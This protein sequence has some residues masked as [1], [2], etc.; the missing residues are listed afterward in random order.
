MSIIEGGWDLVTWI[1]LLVL[2]ENGH[3]GSN[4]DQHR[5]QGQECIDDQH[6]HGLL[7]VAVAAWKGT[8]FNHVIVGHVDWDKM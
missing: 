6:G 2:A 1:A 8:G 3:R 4:G 7:G 5:Q